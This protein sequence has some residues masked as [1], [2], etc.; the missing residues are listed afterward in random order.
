MVYFSQHWPDEVTTRTTRFRGGEVEAKYASNGQLCAVNAPRGGFQVCDYCLAT[1]SNSEAIEHFGYCKRITV[2][3][4]A[5]K[6]TV[7]TG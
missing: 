1:A 5:H 6:L 7:I 3:P 2:Q 4:A